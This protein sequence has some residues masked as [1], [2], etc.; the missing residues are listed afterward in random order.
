MPESSPFRSVACAGLIALAAV[1]PARA[2]LFDDTEAR[3]RIEQTNQ[4]I[5][6]VR[7]VLDE[8]IAALEAQIK[9]QGL[10]DIFN[11]L[12]QVKRDM[13]QLRGQLEV[14]TYE[15]TEAQKRQRDL[16][17]DLDSRLR[18][19]ESGGSA[20][21][22]SG[23]AP[24]DQTAP[25]TGSTASFG[26]PGG[27]VPSSQGAARPADTAAEQ[28]AYDSALDLFKSGNYGAAVQSFAG[29]VRAYPRSPLAPSAQY[30]LG[31]AQFA[32]RDFKAA[33]VSQRALITNYPDSSK[34]P[35]ALLNIATSQFELG[36]NP[37]SRRTLE[38]LVARFPQ[39]DAAA[40]ARQRLA[41]R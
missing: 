14:I 13:A 7:K 30:W 1:A 8:R 5:D 24:P 15:L 11:Q 19:I 21:A 36:D 9:S 16:Y 4:R 10:V 41:A 37:S 35:D 25:G 12:E 3:Q 26:P 6:Q 22:A 27:A 40:K 23:S 39:S 31:N 29:F 38:D 2:A 34:V 20:P 33:I 32:L 17:V 28:R 18:R